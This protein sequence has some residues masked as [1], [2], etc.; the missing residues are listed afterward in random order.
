MSNNNNTTK[1]KP[2]T[3]TQ[4]LLTPPS[5]PPQSPPKKS[6][7]NKN[8]D[9]EEKGTK[10]EGETDKGFSMIHFPGT[11]I[12]VHYAIP[13]FDG[14]EKVKIDGINRFFVFIEETFN[15]KITGCIYIQTLQ[16]I[17]KY[18]KILKEFPEKISSNKRTEMMTAFLKYLNENCDK[19]STRKEV[20]HPA[21]DCK[22]K[23]ITLMEIQ[24]LHNVLIRY[25]SNH[26]PDDNEKGEVWEA[27]LEFFEKLKAGIGKKDTLLTKWN[28]NEME[29]TY[30]R[31]EV[32][33]QEVELRLVYNGGIPSKR[34]G[35]NYRKR[36][37]K[38]GVNNN[39]NN[40]NNSSDESDDSP[41]DDVNMRKRKASDYS[42]DKGSPSKIKLNNDN[43]KNN[44]PKKHKDEIK[45]E[46]V[47]EFM[48]TLSVNN[49]SSA[50]VS[51]NMKSM[52]NRLKKSGLLL[53]AKWPSN[54]DP[55]ILISL[56][57][58]IIQGKVDN[59][60]MSKLKFYLDEAME[61][62]TEGESDSE[63]DS[64]DSSKSSSNAGK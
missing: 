13:L 51:A 47:I 22:K 49:K 42:L 31:S 38:G 18:E 7:E 2:K 53:D 56:M 57:N 63:G 21:S 1:P 39:N 41:P 8:P 35:Q 43:G 26:V 6:L 17:S 34:V 59:D 25:E 30:T 58:A 15:S 29:E 46:D 50:Q 11:N 24:D 48:K 32:E 14:L 54:I 20:Y 52:S 27:L 37:S 36:K 40:N 5:T 60:T 19:S 3:R 62:L 16:L 45:C 64:D 28:V 33:K 61:F 4:A 9:L 55:V 44:S 12:F 10:E 23:N